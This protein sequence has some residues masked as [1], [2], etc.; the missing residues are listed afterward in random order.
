MKTSKCQ[1]YGAALVD[2][3]GVTGQWWEANNSLKESN[4]FL[5]WKSWEI[6]ILR[7]TIGVE[8]YLSSTGRQSNEKGHGFVGRCIGKARC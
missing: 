6:L 7:D 8:E 5:Y 4:F 2:A 1:A 3:H